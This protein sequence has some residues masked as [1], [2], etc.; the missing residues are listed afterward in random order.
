MNLKDLR[1]KLQLFKIKIMLE[2]NAFLHQNQLPSGDTSSKF[3]PL[4]NVSKLLGSKK[5]SLQLYET[6][7]DNKEFIFELIHLLGKHSI[8]VELIEFERIFDTEDVKKILLQN[9]NTQLT[10]RHI[11]KSYIISSNTEMS[12][13]VNTYCELLEKISFLSNVAKANFNKLEDQVIFIIAQ[14]ADYIS[15]DENYKDVSLSELTATSSLEGALLKRKTVCI[16]L[17]PCIRT[18]SNRFGC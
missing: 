13:P 15:I 1:N 3:G 10:L 12:Y 7:I 16:R 8:D 11:I 18:L 6:D 9:P 17:F 4:K 5:I 2:L 14:L